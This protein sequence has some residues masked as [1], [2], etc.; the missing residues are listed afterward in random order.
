MRPWGQGQAS[1]PYPGVNSVSGQNYLR[2]SIWCFLVPRKTMY[3]ALGQD[4][5]SESKDSPL[6]HLSP[7]QPLELW[8]LRLCF[9][10]SKDRLRQGG[11]YQNGSKMEGGH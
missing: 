7:P 9:L 10:D 11:F 4:A 6:G 2:G 3:Y 1:G 8:Y 5:E